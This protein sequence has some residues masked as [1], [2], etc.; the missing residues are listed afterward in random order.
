MVLCTS[1]FSV[2]PLVAQLKS[3]GAFEGTVCFKALAKS[4]HEEIVQLH[5]CCRVDNNNAECILHFL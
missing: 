4:Y 5:V 2:M 1:C 3:K